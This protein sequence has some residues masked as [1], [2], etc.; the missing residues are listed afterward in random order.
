MPKYCIQITQE[1]LTIHQY[2]IEADSEE[3][4]RALAYSVYDGTDD[5]E[6]G[7]LLDSTQWESEENNDI[8]SVQELSD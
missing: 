5:A 3:Q 1:V 2:T 6:M 7:T 8:T 4:A